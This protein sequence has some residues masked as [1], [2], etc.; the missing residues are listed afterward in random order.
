MKLMKYAILLGIPFT[1]MFPAVFFT[2][3]VVLN[4]ATMSVFQL[5]LNTVL[6]SSLGKRMI[7]L[8][9]ILPGSYKERLV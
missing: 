8:P 6:F 5:G 2:Q 9:E 3:G 4:W 1:G 7:G